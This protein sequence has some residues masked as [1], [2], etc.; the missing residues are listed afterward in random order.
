MIKF[1]DGKKL[2][3]EAIIGTH[4]HYDHIGGVSVLKEL[5]KADFFLHSK[6]Q[7]ILKSANLYAV[8][9][10]KSK[11]IKIP[12]IDIYLDTIGEELNINGIKV[13][14]IMTPGHRRKCFYPNM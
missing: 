1:I 11:L 13:K 14:I 3:V 4:G 5:Y 7:R 10:E 8:V 9:I 12:E 2:N 6:D